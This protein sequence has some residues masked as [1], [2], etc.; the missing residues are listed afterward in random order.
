MN[1]ELVGSFFAALVGVLNPAGKLAV[2]SKLTGGLSPAVRLRLAFWNCGLAG[3]ILLFFLWFGKSILN[4]FG[5]QLPA[6][7]VGGAILLFITAVSIFQGKGGTAVPERT[8]QSPESAALRPFRR[9]CGWSAAFFR[10]KKAVSK[11]K[12]RAK[13]AL[14]SETQRELPRTVTPMAVP[15]LAGPGTM[16]TTI[17][18]GIRAQGTA[19]SWQLSA[20]LLLSF[21]FVLG[22]L[23]AGPW[24]EKYT[25]QTLLSTLIPIFALLLAGIAAQ[26]FFEGLAQIIQGFTFGVKK[27]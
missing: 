5:I 3:G 17:L 25:G 20:T 18:F 24:I 6:F 11:E 8:G 19:E 10:G 4:I 14:E 26:L 16:V 1:W 13:Q 22:I 23:S 7:Q 27:I 21:L 12:D 2:W 15:L 9:M